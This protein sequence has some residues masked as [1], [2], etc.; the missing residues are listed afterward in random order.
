VSNHD[1]AGVAGSPTTTNNNNNKHSLSSQVSLRTS[2]KVGAAPDSATLQ[3]F[4][5][6]S[7]PLATGGTL[8]RPLVHSHGVCSKLDTQVDHSIHFGDFHSRNQYLRHGITTVALILEHVLD[9]SILQSSR[10]KD[11]VVGARLV[12]GGQIGEKGL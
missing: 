3:T 7:I 4:G 9:V 2:V 10:K 12:T 8:S 1:E 5:N 6:G 11:K